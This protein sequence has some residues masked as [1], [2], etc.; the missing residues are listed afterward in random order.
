MYN[1]S[2]NIFKKEKGFTLVELL[3]VIVV[4]VVLTGIGIPS[5][6]LINNKARETAAEAEINNIAKALEIY[7]TDNHTYPAEGVFPDRLRTS[8]IMT[9]ISGND[10]WGNAYQYS[11]SSSTSYVLKSYG[12]NKLDGG[13]D[14][15]V[16]ANG[17]MTEDGAY[18]NK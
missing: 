14:D 7:I 9:N 12:I 13:N 8:G 3:V 11:S 4:L 18:P 10:I 5:Y 16:F 17:I 2:L 1:Y 6:V 15:I